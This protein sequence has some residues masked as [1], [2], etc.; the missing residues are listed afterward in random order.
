MKKS[1]TLITVIVVLFLLIGNKIYASSGQN[2]LGGMDSEGEEFQDILDCI[3]ANAD[4]LGFI[5]MQKH[6]LD[7]N[8]ISADEIK[9]VY[10]L[11]E[12]IVD[13]YS[14]KKAFDQLECKF[15]HYKIP[16]VEGDYIYIISLMK[17]DDTISFIGTSATEQEKS[18]VE[19]A[20]RITPSEL[21]QKLLEYGINKDSVRSCKYYMVTE[22]ADS[23][24][25]CIRTDEQEYLIVYS[26]YPEYFGIENGKVYLAEEVIEILKQYKT[27][28]EN[29]DLVGG[30]IPQQTKAIEQE[31]EIK[32]GIM[33][34]W[35]MIGILSI[36]LI[37]IIIKTLK[38]SR[39]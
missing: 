24:F 2:V 12:K 5:G 25:I 29:G 33:W 36:G 1:I 11:N 17:A 19:N 14:Q 16:I 34:V 39:Y 38:Q 31:S 8:D 26:F 6:H 20:M 28:S 23:M 30:Y 7:E 15:A 37:V 10:F 32:T 35:T 9:C 13:G 18:I 3:N 27:D 22:Y 21:E 4:H